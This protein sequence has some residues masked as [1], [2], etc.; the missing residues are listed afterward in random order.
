M[1]INFAMWSKALQG[2]PRIT[3][4]EWD[5][6]DLVSRWLIA[7]RAMALVLSFISATIAGLLALQALIQEGIIRDPA[8]GCRRFSCKVLGLRRR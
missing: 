7:T 3:K 5:D 6:L 4:E 1:K 8:H 2:V